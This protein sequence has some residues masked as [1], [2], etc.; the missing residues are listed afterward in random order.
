MTNIEGYKIL[1]DSLLQTE[2][3]RGDYFFNKA[4]ELRIEP[5]HFF[6]DLKLLYDEMANRVNSKDYHIWGEDEQGNKEY[7]YHSINFFHLTND[8][9]HCIFLSRDNIANVVLPGL[10]QFGELIMRDLKSQE[11]EKHRQLIEILR[12]SQQ[13]TTVKSPLKGFISTL[14]DTQIENLYSKMQGN[15]IDTTPD[16]FKAIFKDE[17]L[18]PDCSIKWKLTDRLLGY[19]IEQLICYKFIDRFTDINKAIKEYFINQKGNTFSDSIRQNRSGSGLNKN[20]KPNHSIE[21]DTILKNLYTPL[22]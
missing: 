3:T 6:T 16:K 18:P 5:T 20:S 22:Q 13:T 1:A 15:Y 7:L 17:P 2:N 8:V 19:F 11:T 21:I 10:Q 9:R 14:N 12:L 4:K